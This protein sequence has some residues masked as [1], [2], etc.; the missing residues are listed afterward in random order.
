MTVKELIDQLKMFDPK[1]QII[2][3]G[4]EGGMLDIGSV[5]PTRIA[6]NVN[7]AWYYG[8]HE[9]VDNYSVKDSLDQYTVVDA[10]FIG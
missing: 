9:L 6:L 2:S 4:Y 7:T 3:R 5:V 1:L 10:V 8:P